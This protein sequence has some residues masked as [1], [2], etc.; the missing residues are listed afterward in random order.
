MRDSSDRTTK[1]TRRHRST[2]EIHSILHDYRESGLSQAAFASS[3]G[4]PLSTLTNWLQRMRSDDS[5]SAHSPGQGFVEAQVLESA[6]S[7]VE[8][9]RY[10]LE[11]MLSPQDARRAMVESVRLRSGFNPDDLSRVLGVLENREPTTKQMELRS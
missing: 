6:Q 8:D 7:R 10:D 11:L 3:R 2:A 5:S 1:K 4:L 9:S